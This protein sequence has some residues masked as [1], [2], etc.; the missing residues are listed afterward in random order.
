MIAAIAALPEGQ[1]AVI[2]AVD[3]AG[4]G[5]AEAAAQLQ[6]PVGTVMSRLHRGRARLVSDVALAA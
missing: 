3:V 1:R 5:Y 4:Y 2:A 6:I